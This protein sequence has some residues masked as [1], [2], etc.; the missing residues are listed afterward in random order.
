VRTQFDGCREDDRLP[1]E[2]PE[3]VGPMLGGKGAFRFNSWPV[4]PTGER[5]NDR[6]S[7]GTREGECSMRTNANIGTSWQHS[8][9]KCPRFVS[10]HS[11]WN[12]TTMLKSGIHA[13]SCSATETSLSSPDRSARHIQSCG[14]KGE[15]DSSSNNRWQGAAERVLRRGATCPGETTRYKSHD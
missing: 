9:A 6:G 11:W 8:T 10:R 7:L 13:A 12:Q 1:R 3:A 5:P 2:F 15:N 4:D 14:M